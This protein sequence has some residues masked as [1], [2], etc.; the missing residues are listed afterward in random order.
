[1]KKL[2]S[3]PFAVALLLSNALAAPPPAASAVRDEHSYAN[4][5]QFR[6]THA[7]LKLRADFEQQRLIGTVDLSLDRLDPNAREI[8]LDTRD[9]DIESVKR[10][11]EN[12]TEL[13]FRLGKRDAV[14]GAPLYIDLP[15]KESAPRVSIRV[16]YRTSP[17]SSGLQWLNP[18]QTA[19]KQQPF[20]Y[21][22]SQAIHARSWIPLQDTPSV[23]ITYESTIQT[24]KALLAVMSA[25][26]APDTARDGEYSFE[27]PQP[28]P[29]YLFALS[30]GD[31][32]FKPIGE[33]TGV[34]A[35]RVVVDA[36]AYE[37][38]DVESM[39]EQCEQMFGPYRWSRYD[40]LIL[41][42]SFMWGG[43][44]NPRLS[45]ITP[46]TIAGDR[47]LVALIAHELAHSWS[48]NLVT[49]ATWDSVWLNEGFTTYLERRIV[50]KVYGANRYAME[51]VLGLQSLERDIADFE[52]DGDASMTRLAI[53]LH[54][55]DPDDGFSQVP[56]EKGRLFLGFLEA[57][58]GRARL[59]AFLRE[60]FDRFAFRSVTTQDFLDDLSKH[61]LGRPGVNLTMAEVR[62]WIDGTGIPSLA[63]LPKSD[64]FTIVDAQRREWLDGK[65]TVAQ[66]ETTGWTTQQWLNFLDGMPAD[67]S[68]GRMAEL[69]AKFH[70]T[71]SK[72][73]EIAHSWL[74]NAI[75][76][77]YAP[78]YPQLERYLTTIG[79][80]KLVRPLYEE[81]MKSPTGAAMARSIYAKARPLYQVPLAQQLDEI[82][83]AGAPKI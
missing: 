48:G 49:N 28:I 54:G 37:F 13:Q 69:D 22:Q 61:L 55:R 15:E 71:D 58:L 51:D 68:A 74:L 14:L 47:S 42:P 34:Y 29:S 10:I 83:Q 76:A 30:I 25:Q 8:V 19:G 35:E 78:A 26:N 1:M 67:L 59:D 11:G 52:R 41:P 79:R 17:Q 45:F 27:M 3:A 4:T 2:S 70:L 6:A 39:L 82:V 64:A 21:S 31:F 63:V 57:R 81:L 40:L 24:P 80:R 44:E 77:R 60:Y 53:D 7:A 32:V 23:R 38:A 46:T 72:N 75:R 56:Y 66:L 9:L 16:A 62:T 18:A 12:D 36:A 73:A 5:Q 33:R 65:L 20:M 43:M 50:E